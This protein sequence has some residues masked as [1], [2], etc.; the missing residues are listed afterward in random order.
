MVRLLGPLILGGCLFSG[1]VALIL[2]APEPLEDLGVAGAW[3]ARAGFA[4]FP[5]GYGGGLSARLSRL[6]V[7]V[8]LDKESLS[9]QSPCIPRGEGRILELTYYNMSSRMPSMKAFKSGRISRAISQRGLASKAG[10]SFRTIQLLESGKHDGRL[11]T[12]EKVAR[13]LGLPEGAIERT[14]ERRLSRE[15]DSVIDISER[16]FLDG[17][18]SW[19]V[20]LF[21]F[22]DA[23]RRRPRLELLADPPAP[24][25]PNPLLCLIASTVESLCREAGMEPPAWC[26]GVGRLG[27]PWFVSGV[28]SLKAFALVHS[29]VDF[30][31]RNVFVLD[32]FLDRA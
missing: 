30:R 28:Q 16:I 18:A 9:A 14:I 7:W 24:E 11:S 19:P 25:T 3:A 22:V 4:P 27:E 32:N 15:V 31:K 26:P 12:F 20:H 5:W 13:S 10:V 8:E 6:C 1:A 23:F 29:P 2:R 17:E 21:N